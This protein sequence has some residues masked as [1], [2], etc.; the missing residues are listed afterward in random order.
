MHLIQKLDV[1]LKVILTQNTSALLY[2]ILTYKKIS[3][4]VYSCNF[5]KKETL[6]Q[7][8]SCAFCQ[9]FQLSFFAEHLRAN[10]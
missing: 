9:I 3:S 1:F 10:Y 8:F 4:T 6:A 5:I 2:L 7:A